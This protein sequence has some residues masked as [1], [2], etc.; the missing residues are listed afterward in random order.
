MGNLNPSSLLLALVATVAAHGHVDWLVADGVAYRGWD[1]PAF[2][3]SPPTGPVVGWK[4]DAPDNGFV[5]PVNFG[6]NDI[7]CHKNGSPAGGHATVPAGAKIQ[8]IWNTW[9]DSHKG[10]VIDYLAK[11]SGDCETVDKTSLNFFKIDAGGVVDMSLQ[12]GKWADDVLIAN[13]FT[14]TVQIP[15]TL[16]PGNYVLRHEI[17][18][19][20]SGGNPNGAQAYPQ[21]FNLQVTGGGSLAPAGVKGTALYKSNDPGILFNIY[22]SPIVYPMPGPT[23][24]SGLPSTVA[25]SV[26]KPTATSSATPAGGNGGNGGSSPTTT[27]RTTTAPAPVTTTRPGTTTTTAASGGGGATVPKYGQCGGQGW[28]G[29]TTCVAGSTCQALNEFYSQC[30]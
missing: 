28:T 9:P 6:T 2:T 18:A 4:I 22:T 5:E 14:W 7:I 3:Y 16:A 1:S 20:H 15:P 17:I 26:A 10:P 24:V 19:L 29:S 13:S 11:C 21:C 27:L 8:L 30:V 23:L 12:N 25:Q